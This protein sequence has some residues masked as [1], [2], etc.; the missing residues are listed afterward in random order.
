M[1]SRPT[2]CCAFSGA[3]QKLSRLFGKL[4]IGAMA[5][6]S[7][8]AAQEPGDPAVLEEVVVTATPIKDSIEESLLRQQAAENVVNVIA[9]DT[10]GRFPDTT[11]AAAPVSYTHLTLPTI[12]SV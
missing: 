2:T 8:A 6:V 11:A 1:N 10:I 12:Y 7:V 9:S 3:R 5:C 4:A